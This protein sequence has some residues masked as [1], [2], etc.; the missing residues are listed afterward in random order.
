[1]GNFL[2]GGRHAANDFC[3]L[4][5][6]VVSD[7]AATNKATTRKYMNY[8]GGDDYWFP[9]SVRICQLAMKEAV[10]SFLNGTITTQDC[11]SEIAF[12]VGMTFTSK[13]LLRIQHI[14]KISIFLN[15]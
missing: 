1:M 9:C 3:G 8:N 2:L 7:S 12:V 15:A 4:I 6:Q 11:A 14:S 13:D 10:K 5:L